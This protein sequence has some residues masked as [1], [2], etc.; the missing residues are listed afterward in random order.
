MKRP[1]SKGFLNG[2]TV[3]AV[4]IWNQLAFSMIVKLLALRQLAVTL[5]ANNSRYH[6][7]VLLPIVITAILRISIG[8]A[9][10]IKVVAKLK[11]GIARIIT[12]FTLEALVSLGGISTR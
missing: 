5:S 12:S 3:Q 4:A 9:G 11:A 8:I 6:Q 7:C 10:A 2:I 1:L